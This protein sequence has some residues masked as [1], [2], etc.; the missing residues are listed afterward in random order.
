MRFLLALL[1]G[2]CL[3]LLSAS[4]L[5]AAGSLVVELRVAEAYQGVVELALLPA[6]EN[7][8]AEG[9]IETFQAPGTA[10]FSNLEPGLWHLSATRRGLW[11]KSSTVHVGDGVESREVLRLWPTARVTGTFE[12][13]PGTASPG[14][15]RMAFLDPLGRESSLRPA[16]G[17]VDCRLQEDERRF[18]CEP[19]AGTWHLHLKP[20][21]MLPHY[22]WDHEIEPLGSYRVGQLR[23]KPGASL[24]GAVPQCRGDEPDP[25]CRARLEP[26]TALPAGTPSARKRLQTE[27]ADEAVNRFG[28]FLFNGVQPGTYRLVVEKEGF[29]PGRFFPIT[30]HPGAESTL[31]QPL[32]LSPPLTLH[33]TISPS[34]SPEGRPWRPELSEL[35]TNLTPAGEAAAAEAVDGSPGAWLFKGLA[36]GPYRLRISDH[37]GN[38]W[39]SQELDLSDEREQLEVRL[40]LLELVGRIHLGEEPLQGSLVF[41]GKYSARNR[42]RTSSDPSGIFRVHLPRPGLWRIGVES[43]SLQVQRELTFVEVPEPDEEGISSLEIVI[44]STEVSGSVVDQL[45]LPAANAPV[46]LELRDRGEHLSI[47]ADAE[48]RYHFRGLPFGKAVLQARTARSASE[49]TLLE[50]SEALPRAEHDLVLRPLQKIQGKLTAFGGAPLVGARVEGRGAHDGDVTVTDL[51]GQYSMHLPS[52]A[53]ELDLVI[54]PAAQLPLSFATVPIAD[55]MA[56]PLEVDAEGGTLVLTGFGR[57]WH[58]TLDR[59]AARREE[60]WVRHDQAELQLGLLAVWSRLQSASVGGGTA[61]PVPNLEAGSYSFCLVEMG[62]V[63]WRDFGQG[64]PQDQL[65]APC[66]QAEV[67]PGAAG[68]VDLSPL[69]EE[70]SSF[71]DGDREGL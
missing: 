43:A 25:T 9:K 57:G 16:A 24:S 66:V 60:V 44:P 11:S 37:A 17:A 42:I 32:S 1:I 13:P 5:L 48:G 63:F 69:W 6:F 54:Y 26:L 12:L 41:G 70:V 3:G 27:L 36:P 35:G 21:G 55:G 65:N 19:P 14:K 53:T 8:P 39:S 2:L 56:G 61:L 15:L 18:V 34:G 51:E 68:T 64:V 50:L 20:H 62:E 28:Y 7:P 33:L 49:L 71:E 47:R 23:W 29:A 31:A 30:V 40:P 67:I 59:L 22:F 38:L 45:G 52:S 46:N 10:R 58:E 4:Q